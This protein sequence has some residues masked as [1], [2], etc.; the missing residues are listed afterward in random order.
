MGNRT[1]PVAQSEPTPT[2]ESSGEQM[3]VRDVH[4]AIMRERSEPMEGHEPTPL[5]LVTLIGVL[6]F[7][8][9]FYMQR[10]SG[11]FKPL[12]FDERSSGQMPQAQGPIKVD[13]VTLGKRTFQNTCQ[14][15]HQETGLGLPGQYPPLAGSEWV[16]AADPSR[17]IRI[18]LDG[19]S[20]PVQVKGQAFNNTMVPWRNTFTDQQIAAVLTYV[21]Q[22]WG[23]KAAPVSEDQVKAIR[24]QTKGHAGRPWSMG[25]LEQVT[26]KK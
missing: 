12:V 4:A 24:E 21:R 20:G 18:V 3:D 25:E 15:C 23:N 1:E 22:G 14:A 13:M 11:G 10:Y 16:G 19:F 17:I 5:W 2:F 6:L 7:W 9:G 26:L 8:G